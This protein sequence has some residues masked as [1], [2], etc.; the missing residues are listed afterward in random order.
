MYCNV[1]KSDAQLKIYTALFT[2]AMALKNRKSTFQDLSAEL[3]YEIFDYFR[4]HELYESFSNLNHRID[5]YLAQLS[6]IFITDW[7]YQDPLTITINL[8]DKQISKVKSIKFYTWRHEEQHVMREFFIQYPL[9]SFQQLRSLT[10]IPIT[11]NIEFPLIINQL[12]LLPFLTFLNIQF[13]LFRYTSDLTIRE[14]RLACET[15]ICHCSTLK[16]LELQILCDLYSRER[17]HT[18]S[19]FTQSMTTNIKHF[20]IHQIYFE[21]FDYILSPSFLPHIKSL[22]VSLYYLQTRI[23]FQDI[24][25]LV[26]NSLVNLKVDSDVP[27]ELTCIESILKRTP[28]LRTLSIS[29]SV[30]TFIDCQK[31]EYFVSKYLQKI[32]AFRLYAQDYEGNWSKS[33]EFLDFQTSTFWSRERAGIVQT[34]REDT[35]D[36]EGNEFDSLTVIFTRMTFK[37]AIFYLF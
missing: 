30:A 31:W 25:G 22:N 34:K 23:E 19:I 15:I 36:Y 28:N 21:E 2:C 29:S 33:R 7:S 9:K 6:N 3:F 13:N 24:N 8:N 10:L 1:K 37:N 27:I 12:P 4:F 20:H 14:L 17:I 32:E 35:L 18:K 5:D 26:L 16:T 11:S